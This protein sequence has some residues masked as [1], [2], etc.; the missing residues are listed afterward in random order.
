MI[1][2]PHIPIPKPCGQPFPEELKLLLSKRV[3][4]HHI[5]PYELGA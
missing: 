3:D 2:N 1:K 5:K 4:K